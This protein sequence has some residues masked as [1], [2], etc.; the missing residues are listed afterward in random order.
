MPNNYVKDLIREGQ[1]VKVYF[2]VALSF[3]KL[4]QIFKF[5]FF[6]G[7]I[8]ISDKHV[9]SLTNLMKPTTNNLSMSC[10]TIVT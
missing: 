6:L 7:I 5:P 3:L 8:S 2:V 9:V 10:L 1:W 4:M